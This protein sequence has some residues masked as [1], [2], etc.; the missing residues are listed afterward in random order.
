MYLL[1]LFMWFIEVYSLSP[2]QASQLAR[3]IGSPVLISEAKNLL[4][5]LLKDKSAVSCMLF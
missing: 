2:P 4:D 1:K 5:P 3:F